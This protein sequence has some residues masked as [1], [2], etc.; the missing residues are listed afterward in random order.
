ME[1]DIKVLMVAAVS[2]ALRYQQMNPHAQEG[3]VMRAALSSVKGKD[4]TKMGVIAAVSKALQYKERSQLSDRQIIA[5]IVSETP[6]LLRNL[7]ED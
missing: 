4:N 1:K 6:D 3:E 2:E 7:D 5:K